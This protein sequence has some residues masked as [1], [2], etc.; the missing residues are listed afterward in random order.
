MLGD[1]TLQAGAGVRCPDRFGLRQAALA[2]VD[3]QHH[4]ANEE[5]LAQ[6]NEPISWGGYLSSADF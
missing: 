3:C 5:Q 1:S 6:L 2:E 4:H